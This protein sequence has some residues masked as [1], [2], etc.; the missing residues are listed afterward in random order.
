MALSPLPVAIDLDQILC[1]E[2]GKRGKRGDPYLWTIFFK[3][4]GTTASMSDPDF[5]LSGLATT[6]P[7]PGSHGDLG[8]R[9]I[10]SG[11]TVPIP[12][13]VGHWQTTLTPI[14]VAEQFQ[15]AGAPASIGGALG[16]AMFLLEQEWTSERVA[17]AGHA[18][19]NSAVQQELNRIVDGIGL[20]H[21]KLTPADFEGVAGTV[22][23]SIKSAILKESSIFQDVANLINK[24]AVLGMQ[25]AVVTHKELATNPSQPLSERF[26][27]TDRGDWEIRGSVKA[28]VASST[29][30]ST[31][32]S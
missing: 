1:H 28:A 27:P 11:D 29:P 10:K 24:D 13:A 12:A 20:K 6:A 25:F 4:D 8:A 9:N 22:K 3:L 21:P 19:L 17:E 15:K 30:V 31:P 16:V 2:Q 26:Q 7:T 23:Q 18:A 14:P 32:A 5:T